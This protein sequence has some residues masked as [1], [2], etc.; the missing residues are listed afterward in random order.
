MEFEIS[1]GSGPPPG[2]FK[3]VFA[4]VE[5]TVHESYGEGLRFSWTVIEGPQKGAVASRGTGAKPSTGN[6]AGK[7]IAALTGQALASG[8]KVSLASCVG[9]TYLIT[10]A[11]SPSG[12]GTR[13]ETCIRL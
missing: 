13:V 1:A 5:Q 4:G 8:Q 6:A 2:N 9:V 3:A 12:N 11:A 10:V 7:I